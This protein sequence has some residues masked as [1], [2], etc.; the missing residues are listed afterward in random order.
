MSNENLRNGFKWS[1]QEKYDLLQE[2]KSSMTIEDIA[3]KHHRPVKVI[4][5]KRDI[6]AKQMYTNNKNLKDICRDMRLSDSELA[7]IINKCEST[8]KKRAGSKKVC[9]N[10]DS[11]VVISTTE[12]IENSAIVVSESVEEVL[13]KDNTEIDLHTELKEM[14]EEI[15]ELRQTI[16]NLV[17]LFAS[18]VKEI[19]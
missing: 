8:K 7:V 17:G 5:G 12:L 18:L 3:S 6:I 16:T 14:K 1:D 15:K 2:L 13:L 19:I 4:A 11:E 10:T 9:K